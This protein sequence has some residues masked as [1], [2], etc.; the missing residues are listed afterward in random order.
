L[1]E[2]QQTGNDDGRKVPE[3]KLDSSNFSLSKSDIS[4]PS[5]NDNVSGTSGMRSGV[6]SKK[7]QTTYVTQGKNFFGVEMRKRAK[8]KST[9][10]FLLNLGIIERI[11]ENTSNEDKTSGSGLNE[12]DEFVNELGGLANLNKGDSTSQI[13]SQQ[14]QRNEKMN[15]HVQI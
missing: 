11:S 14:F 6:S 13:D 12:E 2:S 3:D 5:K 15:K 8:K 1:F 10:N 7:R 4:A 9:S